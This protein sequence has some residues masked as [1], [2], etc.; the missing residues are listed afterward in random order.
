MTE[1]SV[2]TL[3]K[4]IR[5]EKIAGWDEVHDYYRKKACRYKKERLA[6]AFASLLEVLKISSARF[7]QKLF[8]QLL[9]EATATKER[10]TA[11]IY[12]TPCQ[13]LYKSLPAD[14]V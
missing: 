6:H 14:G 5:S 3:L 2:Q 10:M 13:G 1:A 11:N 12:D 9:Q 4:N 7:H 8:L